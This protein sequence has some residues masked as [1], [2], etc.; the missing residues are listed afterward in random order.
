MNTG[1]ANPALFYHVVSIVSFCAF[2]GVIAAG[3]YLV[4]NFEKLTGADASVPSENSSSRTLGKLQ[5]FLI[6]VHALIL[7][8]MLALLLH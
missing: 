2:C 3:V 5:I 7:T 1:D 8:G 6:W 4:R